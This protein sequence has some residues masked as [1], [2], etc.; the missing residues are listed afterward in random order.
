MKKIIAIRRLL[1]VGGIL[2]VSF[3]A[4]NSV[5]SA[6]IRKSTGDYTK[7]FTPKWVEGTTW[8]EI[9]SYRKLSLG[10]VDRE[11]DEDSRQDSSSLMW[12]YK[13]T[14]KLA[15]PDTTTMFKVQA[16]NVEKSSREI[17]ALTFASQPGPLDSP[18]RLSILRGTFFKY[19]RGIG[20]KNLVSVSS[21]RQQPTPV[22]TA[23]SSIIYDFPVFPVN[24]L[25]KETLDKD[26]RG[27]RE[28]IRKKIYMVTADTG[29]GTNRYAMDIVQKDYRNPSPDTF[30]WKGA[31][32][33]LKDMGFPTTNLVGVQLHRPFDNQVVRQLW[34]PDFPWPL[35]SIGPWYKT[36]LLSHQITGNTPENREGMKSSSPVKKIVPTRFEGV[37]N[38]GINSFQSPYSANGESPASAPD[39]PEESQ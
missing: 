22:L 26:D 17:A 15:R 28:L 29:D 27:E 3:F 2:F 14:R 30:L 1:F 31:E 4:F 10:K 21:L 6:Q 25:D 12:E 9:V 34:H 39:L 36:R 11:K 13:V 16:R 7:S 20:D 23:D 24:V 33:E 32:K 18:H 19:F 37:W 5:V 38:T 35:Q 8:T